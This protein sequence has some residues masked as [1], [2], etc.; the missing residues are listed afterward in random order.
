MMKELIE[1]LIRQSSP[2]ANSLMNT[3]SAVETAGTP[4]QPAVPQQ[5]NAIIRY[6]QQMMGGRK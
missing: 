4:R 1:K 6:I 5:D 3:A 2:V